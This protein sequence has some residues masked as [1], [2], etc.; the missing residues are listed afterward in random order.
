PLHN[1]V[2]VP[3]IRQQ[4][5][6]TTVDVA[7]GESIILSGLT[8]DGTSTLFEVSAKIVDESSKDDDLLPK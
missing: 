8:I 5:V 7:S 3:S 2:K 1:G 6:Q 4:R